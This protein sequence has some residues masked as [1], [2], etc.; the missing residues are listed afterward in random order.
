MPETLFHISD[1]PNIA[2]FEPRP[3]PSPKSG[4]TGQMVWAVSQRLLHNY[5]LPRDCPRVTFYAGPTSSSEDIE[6]LMS[7]TSARYIVA[8]ESHWLPEV[9][10]HH[11]YMY[12]FPG[13]SFSS[14]DEGADYYTSRET[15]VPRSVT[16]LND[17]LGELLKRDVELR[18]MPSLWKLRDAII[19]STLQFSIIRMRNA[20]PPEDGF[21]AH[22][23]PP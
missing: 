9:R 22:P 18:V 7:Y 4:Q 6:R 11:L 19:A 21:D 5:L 13:E 15:I 3:A 10:R 2:R 8:I 17:L 23:P 14:V 20:L 16:P 1:I 12:E